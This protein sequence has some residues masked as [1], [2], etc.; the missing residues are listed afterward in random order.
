MCHP[1]MDLPPPH[2]F[3]TITGQPHRASESQP[4]SLPTAPDSD[5]QVPNKPHLGRSQHPLRG[6]GG[7]V[8]I[9]SSQG[10]TCPCIPTGPSLVLCLEQSGGSTA[11][12]WKNGQEKTQ[13]PGRF[14]RLPQSPGQ[15]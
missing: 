9:S 3:T 7:P 5:R 15:F 14:R 1:I 4:G 10:H 8:H 11:I 12:Y 6:S 2:P 13:S